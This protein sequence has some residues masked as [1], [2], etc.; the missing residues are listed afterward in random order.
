MG[1]YDVHPSY[2][3]NTPGVQL[4]LHCRVILFFFFFQM[5]KKMTSRAE[6]S[7]EN[8]QLENKFTPLSQ[9]TCFWGFLL[10]A[11]FSFCPS[12]VQMQTITRR[13]VTLPASKKRP[14]QTL[15][16]DEK[17]AAESLGEWQSF[18]GGSSSFA[19]TDLRL[20][21]IRRRCRPHTWLCDV[22]W[23]TR[24]RLNRVVLAWFGPDAGM[25][26]AASF[27]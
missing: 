20:R 5:V 6:A 2:S 22:Q 7:A 27:P 18:D 9:K 14:F 10:P 25:A 15:E 24:G 26:G 8:S 12:I 1:F 16:G 4:N 23:W 21:L 17:I 3:V 13:P 11:L 19:Q